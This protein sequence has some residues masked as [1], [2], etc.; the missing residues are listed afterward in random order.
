MAGLLHRALLNA[1]DPARH[2]D[3]QPRLGQ[4]GAPVHLLD[5]I[6]QH[7][8]GHVEVGDHAVLERA[9]RHDVARGAAD[10]AFS[11]GAH[12]DDLPVVR[13]E[14]DHRRLVQHDATST[15]V[16]QRVRSTEV[17]RHITAEERQHVAHREREPSDPGWRSATVSVSRA[18]RLGAI[19]QITVTAAHRVPG[20]RLPG[21]GRVRRQMLMI[22]HCGKLT[23]VPACAPDR[24][25]GGAPPRGP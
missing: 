6:S 19:T 18:A 11:L 25:I 9:H 3:H 23:R 12:R 2:G 24:P 22:R 10:H 4:M 8:L 21:R 5:E 7:P 17:N 20:R 15:H 13:I 1:G 16:D 14:R